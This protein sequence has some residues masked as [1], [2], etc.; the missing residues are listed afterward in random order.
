[1]TLFVY[2]LASCLFMGVIIDSLEEDER[3]TGIS[4]L[5]ASLLW[6]L[7]AVLM[8]WTM[9]TTPSTDPDN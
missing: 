6:P 8:I 5:L 7:D 1:M 3:M 2:L 9:I 4:L